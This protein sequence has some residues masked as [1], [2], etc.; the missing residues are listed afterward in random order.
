M[1]SYFLAPLFLQKF[2]WIPTRLI[3]TIFGHMKISGLENL[4]DLK[5]PVIFACN[6]SSEIDPFIVP[7]SLPFWS[8]FSPLFYATRERSFYD[9]NGWRKYLFGGMFIN[10]WGGYTAITGVHNFE[11]S[12]ADHIEIAKDGG[13]FCVYPEGGITRTGA[14]Q[15]AKG[16]VAYLAEKGNCTIV[17]VGISGTFRTHVGQFFLGKRCITVNFGQPITQEEL[18]TRV[19]R[20]PEIG[21]H[22]YRLE[23]KYVMKK[24]GEL[25]ISAFCREPKAR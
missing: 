7:A 12:L 18:R 9:T 10:A 13:S 2:I 24:V 4:K 1:K 19:V 6:H 16:G 11:I 5:G 21:V 3:L 25:I 22:I 20:T 15:Q 8:R 14:L 23:A 17:P